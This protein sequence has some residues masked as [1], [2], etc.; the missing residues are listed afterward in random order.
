MDVENEYLLVSFDAEE[1]M[2][3][4]INGGFYMSELYC[5][6]FQLH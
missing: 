3:K 2:N 6:I 5:F 1:D 4:N